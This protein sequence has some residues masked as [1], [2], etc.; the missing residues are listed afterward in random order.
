MP[1]SSAQSGFRKVFALLVLS[2]AF[3]VVSTYADNV[4]TGTLEKVDTSA[5]T[6][7]VKTA[8][9]TETVVKFTGKTTRMVRKMSPTR[10]ISLAR[11]AGM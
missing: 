10:P 9:G 4:V 1:L 2:L 3:G 8:D 11:K 5:K 6:V 7:A